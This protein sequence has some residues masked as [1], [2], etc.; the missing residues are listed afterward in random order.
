[1]QNISAMTDPQK[2]MDMLEDIPEWRK[3]KI[4]RYVMPQG[5]KQSVGAWLLL[6]KALEL[7][8]GDIKNVVIGDNGKLQ[9]LDIQFNISHS[10]DFVLCVVGDNLVGCDIE[11]IEKA[12]FEVAERYF[13][14][15]ERQYIFEAEEYGERC[16]RFYKIWTIKESYLKMTGEGLTVPIDSIEVDVNRL[17]IFRD[18]FPQQCKLQNFS[19]D[20]YEISI[21]EKV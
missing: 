6:K 18:G 16:H 1:M 21:C 10:A 20:G 3:D 12:P 19:L 11:K 5:R 9:C 17:V 14:E 4:L 8:G 15:K 7:N 2:N 13:N